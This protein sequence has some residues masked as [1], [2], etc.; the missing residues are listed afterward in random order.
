ME[1]LNPAP[2]QAEHTDTADGSASSL[3]QQLN[4][5]GTA[6][7][8]LHETIIPQFET[9]LVGRGSAERHVSMGRIPLHGARMLASPNFKAYIPYAPD[10]CTVNS[11][12][13][14]NFDGTRLESSTIIVGNKN[15]AGWTEL[16]VSSNEE[17][18]AVE[19]EARQAFTY[20]ALATETPATI[21]RYA[22]HDIISGLVLF[23]GG[24]LPPIDSHDTSSLVRTLSSQAPKLTIERTG[25]YEFPTDP[26]GL[27]KIQAKIEQIT[28]ISDSR[29]ASAYLFSL[30]QKQRLP[31]NSTLAHGISFYRD[32]AGAVAAYLLAVSN[33]PNLAQRHQAFDVLT[34]QYEAPGSFADTI[35]TAYD[36]L[37]NPLSV[38]V[39]RIIPDLG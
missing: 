2:R 12:F 13:D 31:D 29:F 26:V 3:R 20:R 7:A 36:T 34:A 23:A 1:Q 24:N 27:G 35:S 38:S 17:T 4:I 39:E 21:G 33:T 10:F 8:E 22:M 25:S 32:K 9:I 37:A 16:G 15:G 5:A 19:F 11:S 6:L 18:G 14:T 30:K 28:D